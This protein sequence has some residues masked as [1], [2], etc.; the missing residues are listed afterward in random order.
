MYVCDAGRPR[1]RLAGPVAAVAAVSLA[2]GLSG[3]VAAPSPSPALE[4]L[5]TGP[6]SAKALKAEARLRKL[7][8][9]ALGGA[10][11]AEHAA[12]RAKTRRVKAA[13]LRAGLRPLL[14]P[15]SRRRGLRALAVGDPAQVGRWGPSRTVPAVAV[16]ATLLP[17]G[18]IL[19]VQQDG[20]SRGV[21]YVYDPVS[22]DGHRVD[23]P[24]N[25]F[26]AGQVQLA[27]GRILFTGGTLNYTG[28]DRWFGL[29]QLWIFD[30]YAETWTRQVDM[31][32]GRWYPTATRL[33][34][35]RVM[36]TSGWD[37]TGTLTTNTDVEIFTPG[38]ATGSIQLVHT[39]RPVQFYPHYL[40][41]PDG[42]A[43]LGGPG[44]SNS[45]FFDLATY[46]FTDLPILPE[47][48]VGYGGGVLLPGPP[49]GSTVA[50]LAGG[51]GT[52][53]TH[54]LN[55]QNA[56]AGWTNAAPLPQTRRN[57]NTV[58]LPDGT[59]LGVG[60][61]STGE[62]GLPQRETLLYT[63]SANT[64][65][66][67]ADQT[68]QRAY[69]STALLLPD[70]RVWSG[71]DN[72][73]SGG[74]NASDA[75]EV[76]EPPYLFRGSRPSVTAAPSQLGYG[77]AFSIQADGAPTRAV[78]MS[79]GSATH[80]N[81]MNQR[82]VELAVSATAGGLTATAP[83][84]ANLAPPGDYMLFVLTAD[85][86]P[87]V[88]R[89]VR[90]GSGAPPPPPPNQ[91][92]AASFTVVPASPLTGQ[93]VTFTD[94]STDADGTIAA[95]AWDTD[96]D[97][98]YD[99]GTGTTAART[100]TAPGTYTVRVQ[101]TDDDGAPA[102]TSR[103]VVVADQPP[104]NQAPTAAFTVSPASPQTGQSVTFTDSSTDADGTIA[105]RAWD[106]D[107]DGSY[108]DGTGATA[109]RAFP[110]AGT[111]TVRLRV[112]DDD[113]AP[114]TTSRQVTVTGAPPPPPPGNL[115]ANPSFEVNT[116]GWSG[117]QGSLARE[118]L[119]GAPNGGAV[120]RATRSSGTYFT[121]DGGDNVTSTAAATYTATAW[122][123]AANASS[124][125]KPIQIK[126]RERTPS[127]TTVADVGSPNLTLTT[128]WQQITVQR[129]TAAG[130]RLGVRLSH[131]S[132]VAGD[133]FHADAITLSTGGVEP[134]PNQSPSASFTSSPSAPQTGQSVTFTDTSTDADGTIASRAWDTDDDGTYDDGTGATASRA[135][136]SAGTFT[137]RL[138][139]VDDDGAP[140][141]T[142]RQVVVAD[143]PPPNQ[144]PTAA[145]TVSPASPQTGQSVT[146]TDSSTDADGTIASRAWD[147]DD[148][149]SYDD[150]T[151]TTASRAFPSA[152]TFTVRLRVTDDDGAPA[153]TS[154]QVTVTGAPPPPPPGNLI[155]NPSFEV[156]TV[157]W[158][159]F[160]GSLARE[161]LAG[162]P[163]G[164]AVARATRSSGTY[165]TL[166][167]GDNVTSTAAATY[168]ATAW[169]KAANASSVGKPIQIK[170][171][172]RSQVG[173]VVADVG[174]VSVSLSTAWQQVTVQ[175]APSVGNRL[176]VR[177]SHTSAVAGDAFHAD[178]ITLTTGG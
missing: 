65:T 157:G 29:N 10:H 167:G 23:P 149:G 78:L 14:P 153:T 15:S 163:N 7:E 9:R 128:S 70:G 35:G 42:R 4:R 143:Q 36:I 135:F 110:S 52:P 121:L 49:S 6:T 54:R 115:I 51:G 76:F 133:A 55:L 62:E 100:F 112:T 126:L 169:V 131:T 177:L 99:D 77:N 30:P 81:D 146:F 159:G 5:A 87:S 103:Q 101:V 152:G 18:N 91:P 11:A 141:T 98:S 75:V 145:F 21:G 44:R 144:A 86:V 160:Q 106:T 94:T 134:P 124:V 8:D 172:E 66:R 125:G 85:G 89:W 168:T 158:S 88:A 12:V 102:T 74:G 48:R 58:L 69:H 96:D 150:G 53:N 1:G 32:K 173:V 127:G 129:T 82:H 162:A 119:A 19:F 107:D 176:G 3:A 41:L 120:A 57:L 118:V 95:R 140:A 33:P 122:V 71:G 132:A 109:S 171:R 178:A 39:G 105:S 170:L 114:A 26:C 79:P 137:V 13:R 104:P 46:Q 117:F 151:G 72:T 20:S 37:E 147:T 80:G 161:V 165:F 67:L 174:S 59:L 111:F 116:V 24:A 154:R 164:G 27:D 175:R 90:L 17:T 43:L 155:A 40:V 47:S 25:L 2:A 97:G 61:N 113:G 138:R 60:G 16:H 84:N 130:N 136:P 56:A 123:K 108:D 148:D 83:A 45:A 156:N 34:D 31:R 139:V 50:F 92:P 68:E 142:S 64:W 166:D 28:G 63:P 93:Q 73:A 38:G 22:G